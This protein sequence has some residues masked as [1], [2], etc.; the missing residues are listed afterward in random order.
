MV[1]IIIGSFEEYKRTFFPDSILDR[2]A[3]KLSPDGDSRVNKDEKNPRLGL[4]EAVKP[5][6]PLFNLEKTVK[7]FY[8]EEG[9]KVDQNEAGMITAQKDKE[10]YWVNP[11]IRGYVVYVYVQNSFF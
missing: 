8:K 2:L 7:A 11:Y 5:E 10:K 1:E 9:Y 4:V 3:E 6:S